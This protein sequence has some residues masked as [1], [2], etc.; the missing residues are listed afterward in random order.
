MKILNPEKDLSTFFD[1][2]KKSQNRALLLDYDGTLAPFRV[3]R[4]KALPYPGVAEVLK[5]IIQ[6][7]GTR[8]V[9]I[10]GRRLDELIPL[11][12]LERL[13]EIWG[14]H[15]GEKLLPNGKYH[16]AV[17]S[18][19]TARGLD[20]AAGWMGEMGWSGRLERKPSS[21][22]LHWR[23]MRPE[24]MEEM[25][26]RVLEH[27]PHLVEGTGLS[28]HEFDGGLELR[29]RG[30]TKGKAV[31]T[32]LAEMQGD[33]VCAYLGDDL[34]DEDAFRALKGRSLGVLVREELRETRAD[35]WLQP[36]KELLD[37]L[38]RWQAAISS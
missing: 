17:L 30:I 20:A 23:G 4:D 3:E 29:P 31:E 33:T 13:P 6:N 10:S 35:L 1:F 36:P 34:T 27:L 38:R 25:R 9:L 15:G 11:V 7:G 14:S 5:R 32:I 28:L 16:R 24:K 26:A 22:A 21:V 19:E 37:F 2:L 18:K 8:L 12:G